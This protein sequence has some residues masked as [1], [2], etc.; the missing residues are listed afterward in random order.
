MVT[1]ICR[2]ARASIQNQI[3]S[4]FAIQPEAVQKLCNGNIGN[5][6]SLHPGTD[7]RPG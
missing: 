6:G 3:D 5:C 4:L 2:R 1:G 7:Q